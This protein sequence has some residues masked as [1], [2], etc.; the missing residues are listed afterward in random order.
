MSVTL[1]C[2]VQCCNI[3][4]I[5]LQASVMDYFNIDRISYRFNYLLLLL[6]N[7]NKF[8]KNQY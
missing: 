1:H 5:L 2:Y 8:S 4:V 3:T 7:L 6:I